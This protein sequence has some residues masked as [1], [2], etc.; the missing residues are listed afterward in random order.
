MKREMH[1]YRQIWPEGQNFSAF[2]TPLTAISKFPNSAIFS[3]HLLLPS[4]PH[5]FGRNIGMEI[6]IHF[7]SDKFRCF[8]VETYWI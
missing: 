6:V 7:H 1:H 5:K 3:S 8:V 2:L 4:L